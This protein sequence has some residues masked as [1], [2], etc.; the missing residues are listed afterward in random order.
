MRRSKPV[1][2]DSRNGA[3]RAASHSGTV[4]VRTTQGWAMRT[5]TLAV[6]ALAI[7]LLW[8]GVSFCAAKEAARLAAHVQNVFVE[9]VNVR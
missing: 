6:L 7:M 4:L 5:N 8:L 3:N 2:T 1:T 9:A